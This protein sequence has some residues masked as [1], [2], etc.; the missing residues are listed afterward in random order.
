MTQGADNDTILRSITDD[1]AFR[2]LAARTTNT[3]RAV[4]NVQKA[5]G[6]TLRSLG[7]LVTGTIL[8]REMMAPDLRV[9]GILRGSAGQGTIVADSHPS[10][11][12]RALVQLPKEQSQFVL[13]N[14]T[15]LQLMRSLPGGRINQGLVALPEGGTVADGFMV[16]LETS[17][18]VTS[19]L[20]LA[21]L[22]EGGEVVAA[23]GYL[24]QLLPEVG[25]G[26]LMLMTERLDEFRTIDHLLSDPGFTPDRLL[27][28]ILYGMPN[29]E[30]G[31]SEVRF[32]CWCSHVR[33]VSALSTLSRKEIE[34]LTADGKVLEITC[35]YCNREYGVTPAQLQG[36][37]QQ[38]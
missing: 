23:G 10:G 30:V 32:E 28:E 31:R 33:L 12:T 13:E 18:Q 21:T 19:M 14:G 38:S 29:T 4:T 34:E 7:D 9:Q 26:P 35:D 16:Y 20:A 2:V 27:A 37:L 22:I 6:T 24:V 17:E 15:I 25:R 1:G 8:F 36:L 3:V 5:T 11:N